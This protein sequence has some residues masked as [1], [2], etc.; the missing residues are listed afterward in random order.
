MNPHSTESDGISATVDFA[1]L[2]RHRHFPFGVVLF[3]C[4]S[5]ELS[6]SGDV[7]GQAGP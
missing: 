2:Q 3:S 6:F 1:D 4:V 5:V 7:A